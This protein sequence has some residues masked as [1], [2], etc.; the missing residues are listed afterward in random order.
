MNI[1]I[2]PKYESLRATLDSPEELVRR[3]TL[4][5]QGRNALYLTEAEGVPLCIKQFGFAN[6]FKRFVYRFLRSPK[7]LRAWENSLRLREAGIETPEPVAY[8]QE[9]AWWGVKRSYYICRYQAGQTLYAWG[10]K[11][12]DEI[13]EG[14]ILLAAL[15]AKMHEADMLFCD[16]TPGNIL[17]TGP[18]FSLVDTNRMRFGRVSVEQ[19]LRSMAGLWLQPEAAALL[20]RTYAEQ[21]EADPEA[22]A[23]RFATCRRLFWQRFARRH[24][25][26][27]S[28][29]HHDLDGS[30]FTYDLSTTLR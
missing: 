5:H 27:D 17:L 13:R 1:A 3:G 28:I 26:T 16:F 9:D 12:V 29:T 6:G 22:C 23:Q 11:P 18:G 19:G 24:R 7:G 10:A 4:I 2:N 21:R 25:L 30:Q 8:L 20:A 14:L 15:A